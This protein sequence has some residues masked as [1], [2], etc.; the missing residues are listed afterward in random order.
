MSMDSNGSTR[1]TAAIVGDPEQPSR[2]EEHEEPRGRL[3]RTIAQIWMEVLQVNRISRDTDFFELGG[4]SVIGMDLMERVSLRFGLELSAVMLFQN[5]TPRLLARSIN[6]WRYSGGNDNTDAPAYDEF[7]TSRDQQT[8]EDDIEFLLAMPSSHAQLLLRHLRQSRAQF[9]QDLFVL[10]ELQFK[11][12]GFFVDL[13]ATNGVNL[14]NTYLLER[15]FG[16]RGI[17]AEPG[18][19]WH[20]QLLANRRAAIETRCV[21]RESGSILS[22]HEVEVETVSLNDLL[23]HHNAPTHVDYL[24]LDTEGTELDI[25]SHFDFDSFRFNVVTCKH[26]LG[27]ARE[28]VYELLT[29]HGYM[30]KYQEVSKVDDWYVS[31]RQ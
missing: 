3:E 1:A 25:L 19:S 12:G 26:N 22:L 15:E 27:P 10:S 28:E 31:A 17:L 9:R 21:W 14:S 16:W 11:Q 20:D 5:P 23:K 6:A 30:R 8:G 24:S 7:Q 4:N 2:H 29:A 13:G 18:Q